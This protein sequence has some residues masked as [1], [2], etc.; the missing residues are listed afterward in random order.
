[1][2]A[3]DLKL[4]SIRKGMSQA[5]VAVVLGPPEDV[6][7]P[8]D[9]GGTWLLGIS[10]AWYYGSRGHRGAFTLG[11]VCFDEVGQVREVYG[12]HGDVYVE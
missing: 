1:M 12:P 6:Q 8:D 4:R 10:E 11:Q 2:E 5:E 9:H 7:T 3:F